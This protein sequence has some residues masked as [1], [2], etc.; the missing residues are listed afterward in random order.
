[1]DV[2]IRELK[3]K[4]SGFVSSAAAGNEF[5]ITDR[6]RPVARLVPYS[7]TASLER[8]LA[9]GWIEPARRTELTEFAPLRS[10]RAVLTVLDADRG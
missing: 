2:G 6:G 4:L 9:E 8:G 5:I 10:D 3:A 1:M 7:S